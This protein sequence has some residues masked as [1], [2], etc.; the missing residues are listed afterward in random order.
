LETAKEI[1]EEGIIN[2]YYPLDRKKIE[3]IE[4]MDIFSPFDPDD[5][6][7]FDDID[8]DEFMGDEIISEPIV[9]TS[10]KVGRNEP[11]PCGSGKKYKKCCGG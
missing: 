5:F 2:N 4:E 10:P 3:D 1:I 8:A 9:R 6:D 7:D 11:C